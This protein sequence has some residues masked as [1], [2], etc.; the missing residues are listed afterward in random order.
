MVQNLIVLG[1]LHQDLYY[2]SDFYED[3]VEKIVVNL[4]NFIKYNPDDLNMRI[5]QKIVQRGFSDTPKKIEGHCFFKRGGNGNNSSEYFASLG[6]PTKLISVIGRG[7]EWMVDELRDIGVNID[8]IFQIDEITPVSTII[9]SKFTTKIHLAPNLKNKMNFD[10]LKIPNE[11]FKNAKLIFSTPLAD[12]FINLFNNA[13][14][15]GLISAFNIERQKVHTLEEL[16]ELIKKKKDLS[17]LNLKDAYRILEENPTVDEV[18]DIFKKFASIRIYTAGKDG[19]Y[20]FTDNLKIFYPGIEVEAVVDRTGAGD[21]YAAGFLT[22]LFQL[23]KDKK[24]LEELLKK[25]NLNLIKEILNRCIE[26]GTHT[27]IYKITK[28]STPTKTE[29]DS[30]IKSFK[31]KHKKFTI[32]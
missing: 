15:S 4:S 3:L 13:V 21:C 22:Q 1:E 6:V 12:K 24:H 18:D 7:S 9:K 26:Y 10:G 2:E 16:S 19:S 29:M 30:F 20:V 32:E 31:L 11:L 23:V 5:L 17:F 27:A 25:E 14:N 8:D 28:Q